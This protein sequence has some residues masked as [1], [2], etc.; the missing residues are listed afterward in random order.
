[1]KAYEVTVQAVIRKTY[2]VEADDMQKAQEMAHEMFT[3]E[4]EGDEYYDQ[5]IIDV[6]EAS[7]DDDS[8]SNGPRV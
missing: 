5:D 4:P 2:R 8:R 3:V 1:M 6:C 7:V